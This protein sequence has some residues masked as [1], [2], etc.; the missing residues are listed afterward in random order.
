VITTSRDVLETLG[1]DRQPGNVLVALGYSSWEKGAP[2]RLA[3][4][5]CRCQSV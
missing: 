4:S 1:T 3:S 2:R 5:R